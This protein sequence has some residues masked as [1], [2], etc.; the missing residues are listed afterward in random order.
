MG[1]KVGTALAYSGL[2]EIAVRQGEM[3]EATILLEQ[4]LRLRQ[5]LGERWGIAASLGSLAW[6]AMHQDNFERAIALLSE[7]LRIRKDIGDP[8]GM[9]WC[10]EKLAEIAYAQNDDGRAVR[11]FGAAAAVR[12]SANSAIDP[13]D[14]PEHDRLIAGIRARLGGEIFEAVWAE[15]QGISLEALLEY[16][17]LSPVDGEEGT[18]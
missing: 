5:E 14:Q 15:G 7:S 8:G 18:E 10:L 1:N 2:G 17:S 16:L 13:T 4:S 9:A 3:E 12:T 6:V 11:I